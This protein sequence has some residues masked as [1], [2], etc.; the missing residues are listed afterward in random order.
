MVTYRGASEYEL[1]SMGSN[2][3][4]F[5]LAAVEVHSRV[6]SS[7][8]TQ[9]VPCHRALPSPE[10]EPVVA[11]PKDLALTR[12]QVRVSLHCGPLVPPRP[13]SPQLTL[14]ALG[15]GS[16][17]LPA[18]MAP[19]FALFSVGL[20]IPTVP[21]PVSL[22]LSIYLVITTLPVPVRLLMVPL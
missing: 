6:G 18:M 22:S 13:T 11:R 16:Q 9:G 14:L 5:R 8:G 7:T 10:V 12:S 20:V 17:L 3:S 2:S 1:G 19:F 15:V 21:V 4:S